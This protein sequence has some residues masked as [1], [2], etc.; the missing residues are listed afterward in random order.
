MA[1]ALRQTVVFVQPCQGGQAMKSCDMLLVA[2]CWVLAVHGVRH[3]S[4]QY[5]YLITSAQPRQSV[6]RSA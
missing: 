1:A 4:A 5:R 3:T 2:G 6:Q